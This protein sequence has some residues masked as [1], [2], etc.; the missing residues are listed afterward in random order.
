[1]S[2]DWVADLYTTGTVGN[3]TLSNMEL[4]FA[5][6][7]SSFS[8][9][10]PPSNPVDGNFWYDIDTDLM[11]V[12]RNA[13]WAGVL[14]GSSA[15]KM[16]VYLNAAEDGWI[17]DSSITDRVLAIKGGSQAYNANGGNPAGNWTITG[18]SADPH[19]HT[20]AHYHI[21]T[22]DTP[23]ATENVNWGVDTQR[24]HKEHEHDFTTGGSSEANSGYA[25]ATG[26]THTPGWRPAA[27]VGTLQYPNMT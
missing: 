24:S 26:V 11:K 14:A 1:M 18:L 6:L 25:S 15:F 20:I 27:A 5:T 19:Y 21:G 9:S 8:G 2:Q 10:S 13:A 16:W 17:V 12:Y 7:R 4:M 22:T 3:T 23:S